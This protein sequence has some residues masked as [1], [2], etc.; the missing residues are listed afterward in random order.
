MRLTAIGF[1][2]LLISACATQNYVEPRIGSA[3]T[4]LNHYSTRGDDLSPH[5]KLLQVQAIDEQLIPDDG[6]RTLS[7][8]G[9]ARFA[10]MPGRHRFQVHVEFNRIYGSKGPYQA[11]VV[12][13]AD[14]ESNVRY[15][16]D[17][18]VREETV[19]VWLKEVRTGEV[20]SDVA[21]TPFVAKPKENARLTQT[22][23]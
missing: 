20:I 5:W 16:L 23:P 11:D 21:A 3:A 6:D 4:V 19:E 14:L 15:Q 8:R 9:K 2:M 13:E 22:R 10:V 18:A 12:V 1:S 7:T 17:G